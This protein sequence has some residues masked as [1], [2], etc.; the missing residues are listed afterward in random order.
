MYLLLMSSPA[1][2]NLNILAKWFYSQI[3]NMGHRPQLLCCCPIVG[4][5]SKAATS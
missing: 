5:E 2:D 4:A 1:I 3:P